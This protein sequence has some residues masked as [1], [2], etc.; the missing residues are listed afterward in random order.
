MALPRVT[1]FVKNMTPQLTDTATQQLCLSSGHDAGL[2]IVAE[3]ENRDG[4]AA[5]G[6][7]RC[8]HNWRHQAL[9]PLPAFRQLRGDARRAG[10]HFHADMVRDELHDPLGVGRR[11]SAA[12]ILQPAREPVDPE[13]AVGVEHHFDDAWVFEAARDCRSERRAQ[14]ARAAGKGFGSKRGCNHLEPRESA[15]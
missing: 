9:E 13:P 14:H 1:V 6:E 15:S 10:M 8:R 4:G 5:N 7:A 11:Y 12:S 3:S 2:D